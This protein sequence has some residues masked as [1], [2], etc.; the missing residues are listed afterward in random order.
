MKRLK[1]LWP[2]PILIICFGLV[3]FQ[4]E[5]KKPVRVYVEVVGD[6]FHSGH[7]EFFK[8]ARA[9]GDTLIVGVQSDAVVRKSKRDPVLTLEDRLKVIASCRYVDEVIPNCP[10][11]V[12]AEWL[13]Q[14]KIDLVVHGD[15]FDEKKAKLQYG[16]AID[17]NILRFVSY[18]KGISTSD[19]I[20]RIVD[21]YR[22]NPVSLQ[23]K[24]FSDAPPP[25]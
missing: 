2:L 5:E 11:G 17:R 8:K 14:Y 18:T 9:L 21:R 23:K 1:K 16:P 4:K 22:K 19:I 3:L 12:T 13:D 20:G 10:L 7:V 24:E 15:D 25:V 6:L